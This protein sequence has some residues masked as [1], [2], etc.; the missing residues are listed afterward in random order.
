MVDGFQTADVLPEHGTLT[1]N[2]LLRLH[3]G[4]FFP[5]VTASLISSRFPIERANANERPSVYKKDRHRRWVGAT[6][7]GAFARASGGRARG[8]RLEPPPPAGSGARGAPEAPTSERPARAS[9]RAVGW[10]AETLG[11]WTDEVDGADAVINLAGRSVDCRYTD[12]NRRAIMQ[13]R[14]RST[15]AVGRAI[16]QAQ[17]PPRV[18][19][20]ASTATIYAHRYDAPNDEATGRIGGGEPNAPDTWRFSI[21]AVRA[22]E[23]AADEAQTP[24]TRVVKLRSAMVMSPDPG[25]V[26]DMLLTLVR[27]GLGGRAGD[28]RQYVSWIHD[29][30]FARAVRFLLKSDAPRGPVNLA[31]PRPLPN[32]AF[33][34]ALR[35]AWGISFG[36]P[37]TEWMLEIRFLPA[38]RD[39]AGAQ[40][41]PR[42]PGPASH[43]RLRFSPPGLARR[44]ARP[45]P[46]LPPPRRL[47]TRTCAGVDEFNRRAS[48]L[49]ERGSRCRPLAHVY[50]VCSRVSSRPRRASPAG[51]D[52]SAA[53]PDAAGRKAA[54]RAGRRR[55]RPG[56]VAPAV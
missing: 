42:R 30:D 40:E 39:G 44:G 43:A 2:Y 56:V 25:G 46:P 3:W 16:A 10:N 47:L 54:R 33:M 53:P 55:G 18:W 6:R 26:F 51:D 34:R 24:R 8:G 4:G 36:L 17:A 41:P 13:S 9:W 31:A 22:W 20:Q 50:R 21:D 49:R 23:A 11:P 35:D 15:R 12:A 1:Q 37:A 28:G 52:R 27:L 7:H 5:T 45:L 19:L 29:A 48:R 32:A 14:V 38:Y